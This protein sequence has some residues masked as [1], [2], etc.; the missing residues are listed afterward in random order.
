MPEKPSAEAR[1][2]RKALVACKS[3]CERLRCE[4]AH[5]EFE[6]Q[7]GMNLVDM[8][9]ARIEAL[10]GALRGIAENGSHEDAITESR[11]AGDPWPFGG[12]HAEDAFAEGAQHGRNAAGDMAR[13]AL[14]GEAPDDTR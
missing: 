5:T 3:E 8:R 11:N 4:L 14:R 10:E 9:Q 2:L 12:Y 7:A 6:L 13:T 1:R